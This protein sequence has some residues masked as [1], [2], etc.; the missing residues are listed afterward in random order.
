MSD[1]AKS[2]PDQEKT[3]IPNYIGVKFKGLPLKEQDEFS[4]G[5]VTIT[6]S[7]EYQ[8]WLNYYDYSRLVERT[9]GGVPTQHRVVY[10]V[11]FTVIT[12]LGNYTGDVAASYYVLQSALRDQHQLKFTTTLQVF[13]RIK[14]AA[15]SVV[16]Y[17]LEKRKLAKYCD[18][19]SI[20]LTV[21]NE[22]V[23]PPEENKVVLGDCPM[24]R[25]SDSY[26]TNTVSDIPTIQE[27]EI[28]PEDEDDDYV[29]DDE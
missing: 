26:T 1:T 6:V 5:E 12:A 24:G 11:P 14:N 27:P 2:V 22:K 3:V 4:E 16:N 28:Y 17:I 25:V 29:D 21:V 9:D 10:M 20:T 18:E 13:E 8:E 19:L 23:E 7:P 15:N